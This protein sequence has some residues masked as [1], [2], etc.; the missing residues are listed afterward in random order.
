MFLITGVLVGDAY[1]RRIRRLGIKYP[2]HGH[3]FDLEAGEC[4]I[5]SA[6]NTK[7]YPI[8]VEGDSILIDFD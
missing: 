4:N 6:F 3:R 2:N 8:K 5:D 1:K 7:V